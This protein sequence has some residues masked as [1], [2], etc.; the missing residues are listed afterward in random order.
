MDTGVFLLL[1]GLI[2]LL[3]YMQ[4][5]ISSFSA[6][7]HT[8]LVLMIYMSLICKLW[9]GQ[10]PP[11][12]VIYLLQGLDMQELQSVRGQLAAEQ[13]RCFKLEVLAG[14]QKLQ[15]PCSAIGLVLLGS[16]SRCGRTKAEAAN[17]GDLA[18]ELELLQRQKAASE[19]AVLMAKQ[20]QN[21]GGMWTWITGTPQ[22]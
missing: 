22:A 13:S 11:S 14:S 1:Q 4:S 12:K 9:N 18:K 8:L 20:R 2:M 10:D 3:R 17:D 19:Q 15:F 16:R 6:G 7:V 5:V 21:S